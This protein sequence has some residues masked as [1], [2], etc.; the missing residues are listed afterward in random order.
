VHTF[1]HILESRHRMIIILLATNRFANGNDEL[2]TEP[3][4]G[5][6]TDRGGELNQSE[7]VL[8]IRKR[9]RKGRRD[10]RSNDQG[11]KC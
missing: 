6:P 7:L 10:E 1:A 11:P 8:P 3:G 2:S 9:R 5:T 4:L